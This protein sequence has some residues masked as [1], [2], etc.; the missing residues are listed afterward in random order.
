MI[1]NRYELSLA[2]YLGIFKRRWPIMVPP[3]LLIFGLAIIVALKI[4]ATFHSKGT[5]L[6]ESQ[7]IPDDLIRSTVSSY[8]EE[9][10][11]VIQQLVMTR[12]NLLN[13]IDKYDLFSD[14]R[15]NLS[16]SEQLDLMRQKVSIAKVTGDSGSNRGRTT[17]A[18]TVGFEDR[19]PKVAHAVANELVTLFLEENVKAR[20]RR[21]SETTEFLT[22]EAT[23]L[24]TEL[25]SIEEKIANYKQ[26]NSDSL[27]EHLDLHI[28][29]LERTEA[30]ILAQERDI[31]SATDELRL[32]QL[33]QRAI[34]RGVGVDSQPNTP[35]SREQELAVAEEYLARLKVRYSEL[36]PDVIRQQHH[37]QNIKL[38][39]ES[40][41]ATGSSNA[42]P[43][44]AENLDSAR[45]QAKIASAIGREESLERELQQLEN[46][47]N[48]LESIIIQTPQV[49]RALISLNRNYENT[50]K[51]Y[52][53]I[54]SKE[55]EAK[56]A[57]SLEEAKKA[58][59]FSVLEPPILPESPIK[60]NRKKIAA[61]GFVLAVAG[62]LGLVLLLELKGGQ[63][64]GARPLTHLIGERP[65]VVIPYVASSE[66][67]V[68]AKIVK[69]GIIAGGALTTLAVLTGI[70]FLL[71]PL[72]ILVFK[73]VARIG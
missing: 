4:P 39:A 3:F 50:L 48:R 19:S 65:L 55:I 47:R 42:L 46:E 33:E 12:E 69:R 24:K 34:R 26:E 6:I 66:E 56:I 7:K 38:L 17:L 31:K 15:G 45:I 49:Q 25:E 2:D 60:P 54:Q 29:M 1:G 68:H 10:I 16:S 51:K 23:K 62:A 28:K 41:A 5:I 13:V 44:S 8:A 52:K 35:L 20:T 22:Q 18:F 36:H 30:S 72:D 43:N 71:M 61:A 53:E 64:F 40:S 9:R 14:V 58:E 59:R 37:I 21:A 11:Q 32:L 57:E 73:V 70:H 67:L 63:L 27:P